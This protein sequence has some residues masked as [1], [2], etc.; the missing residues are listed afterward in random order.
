MSRQW[1]EMCGAACMT[2]SA[3]DM[4]KFMNFLLNGGETDSNIRLA[5][6][7]SIHDLFLPWIQLQSSDIDD[8]FGKS[9]G[10]PYSRT[11][12]GYG[13]GLNVGTYRGQLTVHYC[14]SVVDLA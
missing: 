7:K 6:E 8:Y 1:T 9:S 14:F 5:D 10:V 11:Y 12:S 13:L 3:D 2:T 4:A